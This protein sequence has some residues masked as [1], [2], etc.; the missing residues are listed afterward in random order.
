MRRLASLVAMMTACAML[1]PAAGAAAPK[2]QLGK[3]GKVPQVWDL[4]K[5]ETAPHP[6][7]MPASAGGNGDGTNSLS[8]SLFEN[9]DMVVVGGT[10]TG[11]AGEWDDAYFN[12]SLYDN[13]VWSANTTPV[14]GVQREEPRKYRMYDYAYGIWVP[15]L[16]LTKRT[17]ARSYCRAQAGEPYNITSSKSNQSAWYCSKLAW[18]SYRYT[19]GVD[20][21]GDGGV[22][23]WPI[24][25]VNDSQTS[26]F[27]SAR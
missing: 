14:D 9:G 6:D 18:A 8:F 25:L 17:A 24:D 20:L 21:D 19:A 13:C 12:G 16:S 22:W 4:A 5:P 26:V 11:H 3:D 23:V 2:K 15:S 27:A 10:A 1:A 7:E